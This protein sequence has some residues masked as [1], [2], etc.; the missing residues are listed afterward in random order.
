MCSICCYLYYLWM[1]LRAYKWIR[2]GVSGY[3]SCKAITS[4]VKKGI[5]TFHYALILTGALLLIAFIGAYAYCPLF[6]LAYVT[7]AL[8]PVL[9]L[10]ESVQQIMRA[11]TARYQMA[12]DRRS[13][14]PD[15][16]I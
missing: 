13:F 15:R 1:R 6:G 14:R 3:P 11:Q 5:P 8:L 4:K 10:P 7:L 12:V 9:L 16:Q 2:C